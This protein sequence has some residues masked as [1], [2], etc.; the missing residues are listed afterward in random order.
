VD[1]SALTDLGVEWRETSFL[2]NP[3]LSLPQDLSIAHA[4]V[5][6]HHLRL[7]SL[8][9]GHEVDEKWVEGERKDDKEK[10]KEEEEESDEV[11]VREV[12]YRLPDD[13]T[14]RWPSLWAALDSDP[15]ASDA[16]LLFLLFD[17]RGGG[18]LG[19]LVNW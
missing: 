4:F 10:K 5:S 7:R 1:V 6:A 15:S 11:R 18:P 12:A 17:V 14:D 3:R 8:E 2:F 19:Q 9:T 16:D 13:G